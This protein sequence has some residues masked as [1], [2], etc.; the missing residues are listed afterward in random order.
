V[1]PSIVLR[2]NQIPE[3]T[4]VCYYPG[5]IECDGCDIPDARSVD[6]YGDRHVLAMVVVAD[7][8]PSHA[9]VHM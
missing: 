4:P 3:L 2:K 6:P 1:S 9:H 8:R 7:G 5:L